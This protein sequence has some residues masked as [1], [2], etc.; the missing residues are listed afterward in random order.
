MGQAFREAGHLKGTRLPTHDDF[1]LCAV[2]HVSKKWKDT[3]VR[4]KS[5]RF[6]FVNAVITVTQTKGAGLLIVAM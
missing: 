6:G 3:G 2:Q 4:F 5:L 1:G